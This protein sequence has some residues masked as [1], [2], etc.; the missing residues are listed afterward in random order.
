M[1]RLAFLTGILALAAPLAMAQYSTWTSDPAHSEVDFSIKHGGVSNAT[2]ST[3]LS[4]T[5]L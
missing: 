1:K 3:P 4:I 2:A 5:F